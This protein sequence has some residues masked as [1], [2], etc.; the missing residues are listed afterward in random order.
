M[1]SAAVLSFSASAVDRSI[2]SATTDFGEPLIGRSLPANL[3]T[4]S[5]AICQAAAS[6]IGS[7]SASKPILIA[8][9][10]RTLPAYE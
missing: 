9:S 2:T 4:S 6:P 3:L 7:A 10:A 5:N 8:W 1:I